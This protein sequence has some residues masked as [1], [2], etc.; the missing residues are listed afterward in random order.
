MARPADFKLIHC[1]E[2]FFPQRVESRQP[3]GEPKLTLGQRFRYG[4]LA[5][6]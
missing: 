5:A 6:E 4:Y 3:G 1:R 2:L